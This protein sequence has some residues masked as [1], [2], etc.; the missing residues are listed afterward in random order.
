[1]A[2]FATFSLQIFCCSIFGSKPKKKAP[3]DEESI[4]TTGNTKNLLQVFKNTMYILA[5]EIN[6]K[7]LCH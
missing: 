2:I 6:S 4:A 5:V 1:L 3:R 7:E